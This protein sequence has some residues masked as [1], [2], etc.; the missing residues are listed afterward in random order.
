ML[1]TYR[2]KNYVI[3]LNFEKKLLYNLLYALLRN[4]L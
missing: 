4:K 1:F 3:N 2:N